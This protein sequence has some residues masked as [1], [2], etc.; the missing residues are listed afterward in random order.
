MGRTLDAILAAL[1]PPLCGVCARPAS[2]SRALCE[3]CE[4]ELRSGRSRGLELAGT[5]GAWAA[6]PY[7]GTARG[8][9]AALKFSGRLALA[10]AGA[11]LIAAEAPEGLLD[12]ALVPVPAAPWRRRWRGFD[13]AEEI[14]TALARHSGLTL[15]GCL[16][17][18][19][20][21]RQVGRSRA[22][23]LADPPHVRAAGPVPARAVLVDDV[24]TTGATLSACAVALRRAGSIRV[25]A[26][27]LAATPGQSFALVKGSQAA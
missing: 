16:A 10:E 7:C 1:A 13:P 15:A 2:P 8:L 12:G 19:G 22:E 9:V 18:A 17:R 3:R 26:L 24:V 4:G 6:R 14:A 5:D 21:R 11:K 23:R 27:T 25:V 20:G